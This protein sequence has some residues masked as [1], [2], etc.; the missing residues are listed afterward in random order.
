[1]EA[2]HDEERERVAA[3]DTGERRHGAGQAEGERRHAGGRDAGEL[4]G[5]AVHGAGAQRRPQ[6]RPPEED[7][8]RGHGRGRQPEHPEGLPGDDRTGQDE[9]P[10][11]RE[12]AEGV[13]LAAEDRERQAAQRDRGADRQEDQHHVRDGAHPPSPEGGPDG[14]AVH[15]EPHRRPDHDGR[16]HG[17][18]QRQAGRGQHRGR[19]RARHRQ[20]ALREVDDAGHRVDRHEAD[21]DQRVD[22]AD[23]QPR[24]DELQEVGGRHHSV[25]R[26]CLPPSTRASSR[27]AT[28][29]PLWSSGPIEKTPVTPTSPLVA[30]RA[31]RSFARSAP[32]APSAFA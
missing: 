6:L 27:C 15:H 1:M 19:E 11:R 14:S 31:S 3:Q 28:V 5:V 2:D 17:E 29:S 26:T 20:L 13:G 12:G 25:R 9:R 32:A 30:S 16:R 8:Q 18:R 4:R 7:R 22:A 23:R 21:G 10:T 24:Q